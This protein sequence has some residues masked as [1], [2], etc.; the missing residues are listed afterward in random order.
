MNIARLY[1]S[2]HCSVIAA[3]LLV[4]AAI[5]SALAQTPDAVPSVLTAEQ[6]NAAAS[7]GKLILI[8]IRSPDEWKETG[9]PAS[10]YAISMQQKRADFLAGLEKAT[11]G[12]KSRHIAL[13]CAT[14]SR[15]SFL[16]GWLKS[17]GYTRISD[18]SEGMMGGRNGKGW[19]K[20]GLSVRK[21]APGKTAPEQSGKH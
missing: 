3:L 11:G 21:W 14:G 10:G 2:R 12:V 4:L 6:A 15:S 9:V 5:P 13:I 20:T 19:I 8:D 1:Q 17:Y 16:S 18:V 7:A